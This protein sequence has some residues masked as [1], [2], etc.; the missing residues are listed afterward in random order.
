M[1]KYPKSSYPEPQTTLGEHPKPPKPPKPPQAHPLPPVAEAVA[2]N[3][4]T[5]DALHEVITELEMRLSSVLGPN[6]DGDT[7]WEDGPRPER[8]PLVLELENVQIS[9][10]RAIN[11]LRELIQ[12]LEV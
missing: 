8:S 12:A 6:E 2:S 7:A 3:R 10:Q 1:S 4:N 11:R 5:V 9:Q